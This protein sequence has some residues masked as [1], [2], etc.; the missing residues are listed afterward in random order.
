MRLNKKPEVSDLT[1]GKIKT[2]NNNQWFASGS[3]LNAHKNIYIKSYWQAYSIT[4]IDEVIM[5]SRK[6]PGYHLIFRQYRTLSNG[7][8]LDA[9]DYGLKAWPI[10][11]K[12]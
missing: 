3:F 6:R 10:W 5:S 11:V 1:S 12:D 8:V 2:Q 4:I 9:Y 7:T